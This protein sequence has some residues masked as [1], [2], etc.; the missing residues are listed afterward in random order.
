M[1]EPGKF[2]TDRRLQFVH[3]DMAAGG[4]PHR[5]HDLVG[6]DRPAEGRER[7]SSVDDSPHSE[8][9]ITQR[10]RHGWA[11]LY[12][13]SRVAVTTVTSGRRMLVTFLFR[14]SCPG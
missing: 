13:A 7:G 9:G 12:Q 3:V 14:R 5:I 8:G 1:G 4:Y 6:H 2:R 11:P 10:F